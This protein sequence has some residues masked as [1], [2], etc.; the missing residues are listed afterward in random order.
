M[1]MTRGLDAGPVYTSFE[2]KLDGTETA[3]GLIDDLAKLAGDHVCGT[4]QE[5]KEG[6][7]QATPQTDDDASYAS[8]IGKADGAIDWHRTAEEIE[9]KVRG[10][11][12]WPGAFFSLRH[13]GKERKITITDATI[14]DGD[15][16]S[17]PGS[18][19]QADKRAWA[20]AC[21]SG[22]LRLETVIPAGKK[23]MSGTDFLRGCPLQTGTI[24]TYETDDRKL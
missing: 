16:N 23:E 13:D 3:S 20:V 11:D 8:K 17:V 18:I 10:Y 5:I 15:A 22:V 7:L 2:M 12:P 4:L 14:T 1:Q 6:R 24:L 19:M 21:G 9:R